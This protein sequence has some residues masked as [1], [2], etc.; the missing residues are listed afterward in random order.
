MLQPRAEKHLLVSAS[1]L[2]LLAPL[3]DQ[4]CSLK[5]D[6]GMEVDPSTWSECNPERGVFG[7]RTSVRPPPFHRAPSPV[8]RCLILAFDRCAGGIG[9]SRRFRR[10]VAMV[11]QAVEQRRGHLGV[12]EHAG[13]TRRN[14]LVVGD[15]HAGLLV[16][17]C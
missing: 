17:S 14:R 3:K 2:Q 12:D 4:L 8:L 6:Q 16:E 13:L 11:G 9:S 1:R 5:I 10:D 7:V 15:D